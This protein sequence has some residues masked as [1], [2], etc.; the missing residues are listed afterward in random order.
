MTWDNGSGSYLH[1]AY[2][3]GTNKTTVWVNQ[4][5]PEGLLTYDSFA[6]DYGISGQPNSGP[7]EDYDGD[8]LLNIYE[9]GLGGNPTNSSDIGTVPVYEIVNQGGTNVMKYVHVRL[10]DADIT[11]HLETDTDL[12][13]DPGWTNAG[14][15]I[16]GV[17]PEVD[18]FDT[19]TNDVD[20]SG[21]V[22]FVRL[23]I[24]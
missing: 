15:S 22:G 17:G 18:G 7:Q 8:G 5:A 20:A 16:V 14:W 6:D 3:G 23:V 11:Y 21:N 13:A 9:F 24:E 10:V 4:T 2:D 12:V 1:A 19:V